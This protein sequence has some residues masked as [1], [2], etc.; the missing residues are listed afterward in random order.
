M[1]YVCLYIYI[2][3]FPGSYCVSFLTFLSY[4]A[5]QSSFPPGQIYPK[6]LVLK[7]PGA[8]VQQE[9]LSSFISSLQHFSTCLSLLLLKY[10]I[11]ERCLKQ[12]YLDFF[13]SDCLFVFV[14]HSFSNFSLNFFKMKA[15][16][17]IVYFSNVPDIKC[18]QSFNFTLSTT[19]LQNFYQKPDL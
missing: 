16:A 2:P 17:L 8:C 9:I 19:G 11:Q 12:K 18:I 14:W 1:C 13:L 15:Q 3:N 5:L 10:S 6:Q 4:N 7:S